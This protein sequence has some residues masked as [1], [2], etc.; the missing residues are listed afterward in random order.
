VVG[1]DVVRCHW[2]S[3]RSTMNG[4]TLTNYLVQLMHAGR[5]WPSARSCIDFRPSVLCVF[6]PM[7]E[8][9]FFFPTG[10]LAPYLSTFMYPPV[11]LPVCPFS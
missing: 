9:L 4:R 2:D 7:L 6:R 8:T 3:V 10:L 1:S 11:L 5:K